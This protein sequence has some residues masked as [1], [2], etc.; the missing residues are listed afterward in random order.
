VYPFKLEEIL[1]LSL[2]MYYGP[3]ADTK[4]LTEQLTF[5]REVGFTATNVG[6]GNLTGISG[7]NADVTFD[8]RLFD[9]AKAA[10]M[11]RHPLQFQMAES[12]G[13]ARAIGR[14]LGCKVD[15]NPGCEFDNPKLK[16]LYVDFAKKFA[17]FIK[18]QNLPV[19]VEIVDEPREVPNPWN[20]NLKQTNLYGDWLKE[21]GIPFT[22]VDPMGDSQSGKDY[23]SLIDH[24]DIVSTH[25]GKGSERLMTMTPEK[26]KLLHLYNTGMD[27]LSWGFYNW[28]VGSVGRWE[29]HFCFSEGGGKDG[30]LNDHEWFNPFTG[31]DG[32]A[33]HAPS[34]YPG[35]M[36]FKSV[37]LTCSEGITDSAYIVTLEKALAAAEGDAAKS[38]TVAKAKEFLAQLKTTIPFLPGVKGIA[39]A[40]EGAKVGEG[41][42][43]K[44]ASNIENWRRQIGEFLTALK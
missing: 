37:F 3:P 43:V 25:A 24:S 38:A 17:D 9:T 13:V 40:A 11:G 7:E 35:A 2:G 31:N 32:F 34:S 39:S 14:R 12:L 23:T 42:M 16:P 18:K 41:L 1:P 21:G 28:R 19:M 33:P 15:Q 36:L 30:Y 10:G 5:M 27:R 26:K 20:R 29:W 4:T 44:E 8:Q 22:F 6:S